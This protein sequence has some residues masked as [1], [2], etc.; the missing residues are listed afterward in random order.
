M[1]GHWSVVSSGSQGESGRELLNHGWNGLVCQYL[2]GLLD[3][4]AG[5]TFTCNGRWNRN[6][7]TQ[8]LLYRAQFYRSQTLNVHNVNRINNR[9]IATQSLLYRAQFYRS[10]T[11]NV[12]NVN[13][14][15]NRNIATQSLLYRAQF[16]RSQT[17]NVHNVNR[18]NNRNI[19][20]QS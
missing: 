1:S 5:R 7:A 17:L 4:S 19:A 10:Q 14:I 8:S 9:N 11:L 6:I 15:N 18:I 20:T 3:G 16:Y 13:R 12:H 2:V